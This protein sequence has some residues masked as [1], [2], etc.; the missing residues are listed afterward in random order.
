[1]ATYYI[2]PFRCLSGESKTLK[3]EVG[4]DLWLP[5]SDRVRREFLSKGSKEIFWNDE[6]F[7]LLSV[8]L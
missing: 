3:S 6:M 1:M 8:V 5:V 7:Y 2:I 4:S